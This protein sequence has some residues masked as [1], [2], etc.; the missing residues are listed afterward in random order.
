[1]VEYE[2]VPAEVR[3]VVKV[4]CDR[5]RKEIDDEMEL[6]EV[7]HIRFVGGWASV[8]GDMNE[9]ACDICQQFLKEMIGDFCRFN[10]EG[11]TL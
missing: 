9:V 7:H 11:E 5:C 2:R 3:G 4:I 1:M 8:F 6:Q 10:E